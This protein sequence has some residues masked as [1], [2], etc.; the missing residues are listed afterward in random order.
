MKSQQPVSA[1]LRTKYKRKKN[2]ILQAAS[3]LRH[4]MLAWHQNFASLKLQI[5]ESEMVPC[6]QA[7]GGAVYSITSCFAEAHLM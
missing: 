3:C 4:N 7:E 5:A 6:C 2:E 1:G